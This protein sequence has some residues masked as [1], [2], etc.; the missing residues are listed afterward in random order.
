VEREDDQA[1]P[2]P[3]GR[4]WRVLMAKF[5]SLFGAGV[6]ILLVI[7]L[8][9]ALLA[10]VFDAAYPLHAAVPAGRAVA[11]SLETSARALLVIAAFAALGTLSALITRNTLGGFFLGF[12]F[13]VASLILAGFKAVATVTLTYWVAGWMRFRSDSSILTHIWRDDF[14]PVKFPP[15]S[16]GVIGLS[17]FAAACAALSWL[18]FHRSDVKA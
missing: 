16:V 7:W 18:R 10:P 5:L 2:C 13:V 3:G 17:I 14:Y 1:G 8:F 4:R 11:G 15:R 12:A 9:L 6:G